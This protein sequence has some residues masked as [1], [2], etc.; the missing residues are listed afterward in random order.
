MMLIAGLLSVSFATAA[1]IYGLVVGA[2]S[3]S[4][5]ILVL[6]GFGFGLGLINRIIALV[7]A[8]GK[9]QAIAA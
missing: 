5:V 4:A 2:V 1:W 9:L 6:S 7:L 8:K 3:V